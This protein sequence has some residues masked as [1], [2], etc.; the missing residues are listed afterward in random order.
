MSTQIG[1]DV[2]Q[3]VAAV[4]IRLARSEEV[5]VRSVEDEDGSGHGERRG[6]RHETRR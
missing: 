2:G 6:R 5:E 1:D 3:R 4:D